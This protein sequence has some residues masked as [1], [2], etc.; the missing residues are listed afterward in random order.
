M[1]LEAKHL[2][3]YIKPTMHFNGKSGKFDIGIQPKLKDKTFLHLTVTVALP[4]NVVS[5]KPTTSLGKAHFD[6]LSKVSTFI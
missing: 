2:P 4:A 3:L 5:M 6:P 1:E